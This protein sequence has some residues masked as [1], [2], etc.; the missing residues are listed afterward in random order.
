VQTSG[1]EKKPWTLLFYNAGPADQ[2]RM[3]RAVLKSLEEAGAGE[4]DV[5]VFDHS[6]PYLP[7]TLLQPFGWFRG[8]N[9]TRTYQVPREARPESTPL[10]KLDESLE[11]FAKFVKVMP[12][13]IR[14]LVV[15]EHPEGTDPG[16]AETLKKFVLDS[17][18]RYPAERYA[19]VITGHGAAFGG[20]AI[21]GTTGSR[22]E[23][24]ELASVFREVKEE[25]GQGVD[26]L[27]LNVCFGANLETLSEFEGAV[28]TV[29]ASESSIF[30]AGQPFGQVMT[31]LNGALAAGQQVDG[32]QLGRLFVK[33]A[34]HQALSNLY[35][36][37]LSAIDTGRLRALRAELRT[38]HEKAQQLTDSPTLRQAVQDSARF[39]YN[40][41]ERQVHLVDLGSFL[42]QLKKEPLPRELQEVIGRVEQA[43]AACIL[44][45]QHAHSGKETLASRLL[46]AP[47]QRGDIETVKPT[48]LTVYYDDDV[49]GPN[50]RL[51]QLPRAYLEETQTEPFLAHLGRAGKAARE[52][53]HGLSGVLKGVTGTY[54]AGCRKLATRLGSTKFT[55]LLAAAGAVAASAGL[56]VGALAAGVPTATLAG[57]GA[58]L[59]GAVSAT[60]AVRELRASKLEN[61]G[62]VAAGSLL[63]AA[64]GVALLST[65]GG[66][67]PGW[68]ALPALAARVVGKH[69]P[70]IAQLATTS[71]ARAEYQEQREAYRGQSGE[72]KMASLETSF[73]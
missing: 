30:A 33:E 24:R 60:R 8:V 55:G 22:M 39:L 73:R 65:L 10:K 3:G 38:F 42:S 27:N 40:G 34:E 2:S 15:E 23:N 64:G 18:R 49:E 43:L 52:E 26:L 4:C 54:K 7:E 25:T 19:V 16:Q 61:K 41:N 6:T 35:T 63:K 71:G 5:A 59:S 53:K 44:A 31:T 32:Q 67:T 17:M 58:A 1:A 66:L 12:S 21:V 29:V 9:G 13:D 45:E 72:Q 62:A 48:G 11:S 46:E 69:G 47:F 37:T 68:V 57:A 50:S 70:R 14:S 36:P 56:A 28:P 51:E 20:Q